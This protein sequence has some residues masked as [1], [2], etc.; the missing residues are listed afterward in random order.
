MTDLKI[1]AC[2][3]MWFQRVALLWFGTIVELSKSRFPERLTSELVK[4]AIRIVL[5][6][7][8][9][10]QNINSMHTIQI[11]HN[12]HNMHAICSA[13]QSSGWNFLHEAQFSLYIGYSRLIRESF[14][15]TS[16]SARKLRN[17]GFLSEQW[18]GCHKN[19]AHSSWTIGTQFQCFEHSLP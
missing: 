14:E 10:E 15:C 2:L 6:N 19:T 13:Y 16:L 4:G 5:H 11:M 18:V 8:H 17:L 3:W 1:P 9:D 12:M 7:M